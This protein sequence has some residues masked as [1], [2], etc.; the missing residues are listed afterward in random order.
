MNTTP[1]SRNTTI[2][3]LDAITTTATGVAHKPGA[4]RRT[5]QIEGITTATIIIEGSNDGTN[6]V[7]LLTAT[8]DGGW[9]SDAP[10]LWIR[11]RCSAHT[12]GTITV[13]MGL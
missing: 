12:T 7:T 1:L 13:T 10:W 8:A 3:L 6:Y 5:F 4:T 9:E 2:K 11:A